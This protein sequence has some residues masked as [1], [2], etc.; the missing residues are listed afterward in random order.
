MVQMNGKKEWK[1]ED[2]WKHRTRQTRSRVVGVST[3][4]RK[5]GMVVG[6]PK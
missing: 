4:L 2:E 3:N 5:R 1:I 6:D